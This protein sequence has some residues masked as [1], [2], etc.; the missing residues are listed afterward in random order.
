[1]LTPRQNLPAKEHDTE[2]ISILLVSPHPEDATSL[3]HILH[4]E[5]WHIA[6][7]GSIADANRIIES[8]RPAVVL[9]ERELPDGNWKDLLHS[10]ERQPGSPLLLIMSKHADEHLWAEVLNL[11]GYDVL[12][13]PLDRGEVARVV[14]MAWRYWSGAVRPGRNQVHHYA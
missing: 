10:E 9:C 12:M 14:S 1:M 7:A 3:R 11:G 6:H 13:K 8:R 5:D 4:H 2:N